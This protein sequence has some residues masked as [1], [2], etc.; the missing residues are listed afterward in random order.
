MTIC[1]ACNFF[2]PV[3]CQM[4]GCLTVSEFTEACDC[5]EDK[6]VDDDE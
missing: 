5:Y 3:G 4:H 1:G 2:C 6:E